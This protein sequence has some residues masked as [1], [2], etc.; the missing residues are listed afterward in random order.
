MDSPVI[1]LLVLAVIAVF[2]ILKL[3]STLGTRDGYESPPEPL[4]GSTQAT[5]RSF[6]VIEGGEDH[7][8]T[9]HVPAGSGAAQALTDMKRADPGFN[10][11]EFLGG[12][13][14]AYEMIL[15]GFEKGELDDLVPFLSRDVFESFD[16]VVQLREREGLT[17]D[18]T[19]VGL[20]EL[21]LIDAK[22][23]TDTREAEVTVRFLGELTSI[24]RDRNGDVVEGDANTIKQQR[25]TWTF[26]RVMGS[27]NPNWKLVGTGE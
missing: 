8:I 16:E 20:R 26:A 5:R 13:R 22:F 10:V 9:D 6:E 12:A 23:N 18:A 1:Q 17:V 21:D 25:D 4:Q 24:V 27:D 14:G 15:M 3:R 19:F 2:L 7:D 11:G